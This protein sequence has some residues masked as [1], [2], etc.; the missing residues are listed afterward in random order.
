LARKRKEEKRTRAAI[1]I[2][3][4]G[5]KSLFALLDEDF[6]VL[7]EEKLPSQPE[8]GGLRAFER[9]M[10]DALRS[11]LR[12]ARR[13]GL[14]VKVVGAGCAGRI[15]MR[16]GIVRHAPNLEFLAGYALRARL[17]RLTG[18]NV[19]VANDVLTG[20]YGEHRLGAAR[21]ARHVIGVWL[22]T[23]V[24][25]ALILEGRPYL[26]AG[27][28][29]G[30][31]GNY[32]LHTVDT[33]QDAPRKEVLDNVASR[34]AIAG[35][36]AVLAAKQRAPR[37]R[38]LIGTDVRDIKSGDLAEAIR[39]GDKD[40]ERL[41]RSRAAMLGAAL[42]NLVDFLNPEMVVIG[43]G[44]VSAMP[45][46]LRREIGKAIKAH[47]S[48]RA[49]RAVNVVVAKLGDHAGTIGAAALAVDMFSKAPPIELR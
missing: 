37:L 27:G 49:A 22:G 10:K 24:G 31:L 41:V 40:V 17:E 5:T 25:G 26:G 47:A 33:D 44:L 28:I 16:E 7:A 8:K 14:V 4:G 23:G 21:R 6:E 29:A 3:I 32:V 19:F 42:S 45:Q 48:V 39:Q 36:A 18:A 34:P 12:A 35:D 9:G 1:G 13:R 43:G 38:K 46:L 20:L 15:N 11:L 30:D 2:D